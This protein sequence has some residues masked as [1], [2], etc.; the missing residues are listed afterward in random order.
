MRKIKIRYSLIPRPRRKNKNE[1]TLFLISLF[2]VKIN[3]KRERK[4]TYL[5]IHTKN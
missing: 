2:L 1:I 5:I 4:Q 3:F